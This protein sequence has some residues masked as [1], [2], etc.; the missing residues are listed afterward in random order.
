[1]NKRFAWDLE[2]SSCARRGSGLSIGALRVTKKKK[3]HN[4]IE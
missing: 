3:K 4:I 1:M 2:A